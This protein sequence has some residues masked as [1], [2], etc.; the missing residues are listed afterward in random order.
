MISSFITQFPAHAT[1]M[2]SLAENEQGNENG[3]EL[4]PGRRPASA[5]FCRKPC[6][7][8]PLVSYGRT[9]IPVAFAAAPPVA[10][11]GVTEQTKD[12]PLAAVVQSTAGATAANV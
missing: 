6:P 10:A 5:D 4:L 1:L 7:L 8:F 2:R 3:P 12:V 9:Q 11:S